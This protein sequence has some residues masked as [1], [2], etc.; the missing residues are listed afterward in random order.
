MFPLN[1]V[2]FGI[3]LGILALSTYFFIDYKRM[4][5]KT[6]NLEIQIKEYSQALQQQEAYI[7][8]IQEVHKQ[9]RQ[10]DQ[11]ISNEIKITNKK[12]QKVESVLNKH[13]LS[14]IASKKR[15]LLEKKINSGTEN[16]IRC[17]ELVTG[18]KAKKDEKNSQCPELININ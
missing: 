11:Q 13:N 2:K 8:K 5:L 4:Q 7:K 18:N 9:Q 6:N 16:I 15:T 12:I 1:Y 3:Y 10:I 17:F 14:E